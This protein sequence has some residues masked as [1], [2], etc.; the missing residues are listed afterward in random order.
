[1][2]KARNLNKY[3]FKNKKNEIHVI[4]NVSLDLP[5]KGLIALFGPSGGGKT[6]LLNVIAGLDRAKGEL[7]YNDV[8]Y[9][10]YK[11]RKWD[12]MRTH[13]I[14][15]IFQN[16]LLVEEL[17]VYENIRMTLEMVGIKDKE[18]IDK[19]I[20]YVL[21]SVGLEKYER[22]IAGQLSGGQQQ[23]VAIARALAKNPKVIIADEPTG[24]LDSKNTVE[25]MNII[26]KISEDKLVLLVTH[27]PNIANS[28]ADRILKIEDGR[29][30]EDTSNDKTKAKAFIH[31]S[32]IYLEDFDKKTLNDE[33]TN[34]TLYGDFSKSN[35]KLVNK[36]GTIYLDLGSDEKVVI[37]NSKS[38]TKLIEC[39][40]TDLIEKQDDVSQFEYDKYANKPT[41]KTKVSFITIKRAIKLAFNKLINASR[42]RKLLLVGFFFAGIMIALMSSLLLI[43]LDPRNNQL[44]YPKE[45]LQ[46]SL[47]EHQSFL[48][49]KKEIKNDEAIVFNNLSNKITYTGVVFN[50]ASIYSGGGPSTNVRFIPAHIKKAEI[51]YGRD[52][53]DKKGVKEI[54]LDMGT[55]RSFLNSAREYLSTVGY[56]EKDLV[57]MTVKLNN[58]L[59]KIVGIT[60]YNHGLTRVNYDNLI[61]IM[62][63]QRTGLG[64]EDKTDDEIIEMF[65]N[66]DEALC[67]DYMYENIVVYSKTSKETKNHLESKGITVVN[68]YERDYEKFM[69]GRKSGLSGI[70]T[71]I[72]VISG[73]IWFSLYFIIRSNLFS[74]INEIKVYRALG[75]R[76]IEI[77]KIYL[78]EVI[79][80]TTVTSLIGF[81]F[82]M[83]LIIKNNFL[84]SFN[85]VTY[86]PIQIIL[87]LL[88][89]Y[90]FNIIFGTL[91]VGVLLR[92]TPAAIIASAEV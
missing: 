24:N 46:V 77:V 74:R 54:T 21:K 82:M 88:F 90:V 55:A 15:Y 79:V 91:P 62:L 72:L 64:L 70:I 53:Q 81:I 8:D 14:G 50:Q 43:G 30:T 3:F 5:E 25:I 35:I 28:Y 22:R 67:L 13:D 84:G 40:E 80:L 31:T 9:S 17:S 78:V 83:Y 58:E 7:S 57:G 49:V 20:S 38:E 32:D 10:N 2:I 73:L 23:R 26:K 39:R 71:I 11:M 44:N 89:M 18:Q 34:I 4:N 92:K 68:D 52:I 63:R 45:Q 60:N 59:Y 41:T 85:M 87:A 66:N 56:K 6:T 36:D 16:Y 61:V 37:I 27:A 86:S 69:R 48:D 29:I 19:R 42:R 65:N 33:N 76:R 51:I 1:M 12:K 47:N 75:V